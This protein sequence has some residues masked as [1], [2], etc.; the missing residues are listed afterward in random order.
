MMEKV[1]EEL[2]LDEWQKKKILKYEKKW[3]I[4]ITFTK[5]HDHINALV[6]GKFFVWMTG[7]AFATEQFELC[8]AVGIHPKQL[9]DAR[10]RK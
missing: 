1:F 2:S 10:D 9:I 6:D 5:D 4:K 3:K 8:D 7:I